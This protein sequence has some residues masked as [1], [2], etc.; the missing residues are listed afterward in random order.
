[1][2]QD[3]LKTIWKQ[4]APEAYDI[5]VRQHPALRG[6]LRQLLMELIAFFIFLLVYYDFFDGGR[7]PFYLNAIL[8]LSVGSMLLHN[9]WGYLVI[10][11]R[12][13]G[14]S[15]FHSMKAYL[16]KLRRYA[17]L[18]IGSRAV[19]MAGIFF[20]FLRDIDWTT[21]KYWLLA[22]MLLVFAVQ[23]MLLYRLWNDRI[24]KIRAILTDLH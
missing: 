5:R 21:G 20:F 3:P 19:G 17:L 7:K 14:E 11:Y 1:M 22:G 2:T 23:M 24:E 13:R 10:R 9:V 12:S 4:V 6:I 16:G 15:L 18:A 8:V